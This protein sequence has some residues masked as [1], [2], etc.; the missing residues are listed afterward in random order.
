M[1]FPWR[2]IASQKR[3]Y[4]RLGRGSHAGNCNLLLWTAPDLGCTY[5][6]SQAQLHERRDGQWERPCL[7]IDN[8]PSVVDDT[9]CSTREGLEWIDAVLGGAGQLL[10]GSY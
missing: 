7:G 3:A 4:S 10:L 6:G 8:Q 5:F 9:G 2:G 1:R